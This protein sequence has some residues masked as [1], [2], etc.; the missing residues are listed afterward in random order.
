MEVVVQR[1]KQLALDCAA[2]AIELV[3]FAVPRLEAMFGMSRHNLVAIVRSIDPD[4]VADP[5]DRE[6]LRAVQAL[7]NLE[8]LPAALDELDASTALDPEQSSEG[9]R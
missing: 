2:L 6:Q 9:A 4:S 7:A 1:V 5:R 8:D 3:L